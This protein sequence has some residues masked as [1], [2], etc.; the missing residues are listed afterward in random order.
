MAGGAQVARWPG[1][2]QQRP[3]RTGRF[4]RAREL[5]SPALGVRAAREA[6]ANRGGSVIY[7]LGLALD[8]QKQELNF[9]AP[10]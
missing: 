7:E 3:L 8:T 4:V 9:N 6:V 2:R 1:Q 10:R 5:A